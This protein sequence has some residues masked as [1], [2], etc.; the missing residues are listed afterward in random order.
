MEVRLRSGTAFTQANGVLKR[1]DG[2]VQ[3]ALGA[4][5][6]PKVELH[7]ASG[8]HGKGGA[9]VRCDGLLHATTALLKKVGVPVSVHDDEA[10][11]YTLQTIVDLV[12]PWLTTRKRPAVAPVAVVATKAG[13]PAVKQTAPAV[14]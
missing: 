10:A 2:F 3:A 1:P 9:P 6:D 11:A 7:L 14:E 5:S 13:E 8:R 4:Q 12:T